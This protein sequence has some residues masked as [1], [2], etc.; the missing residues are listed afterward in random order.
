MK[1]QILQVKYSR[2]RND[3]GAAIEEEAKKRLEEEAEEAR[4]K[5]EEE[6]K[7][8]L[9][10]ASE[11]KKGYHFDKDVPKHFYGEYKGY[12]VFNVDGN[13]IRDNIDIDF[14]GGGN[15][16]RYQYVPQGDLPC[17]KSMTY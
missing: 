7:L 12:K 2:S 13:Y 17:V 11:R 3:N 16:A 9:N 5:L 15:P 14:V 10:K 1:P 6:E 8:R 4:K